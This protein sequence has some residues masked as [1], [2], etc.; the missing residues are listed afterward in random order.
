MTNSTAIFR[1]LTKFSQQEIDQLFA[2]SQ[3]VV[4]TATV[5]ILRAMATQK[6]ARL[7]IITKRTV[8]SA[9]KRNRLRR[10]LKAIF[11]EQQL[12]TKGYDYIIIAKPGA[13]TLSFQALQELL[14]RATAG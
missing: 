14:T 10:R 11:Y 7:L 13:T 5:T 12:F 1:H 8:G 3:C 6:L 4:R 2:A 9:P